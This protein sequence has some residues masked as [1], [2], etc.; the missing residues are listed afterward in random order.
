VCIVSHNSLVYYSLRRLSLARAIPVNRGI[1]L[2]RIGLERG[3]PLLNVLE[4][5]T[6]HFGVTRV[7]GVG[8][9]V[10]Q[11]S[12]VE[13]QALEFALQCKLFRSELR[14]LFVALA[15]FGEIL[16]R[17]DVFA[18]PS[19]CHKLRES[20]WQLGLCRLLRLQRLDKS[21]RY[22]CGEACATHGEHLTSLRESCDPTAL[23]RDT[24]ATMF[25][26]QFQIPR[27]SGRDEVGIDAFCHAA[28]DDLHLLVEQ[29]VVEDNLQR[30]A[31]FDAGVGN[32]NQF[33]FLMLK[34]TREELP[35]IGI[36]VD[37]LDAAAQQVARFVDFRA[38]STASVGMPGDTGDV[39]DAKRQIAQSG[40]HVART[41]NDGANAQC[42][43][44]QAFTVELILGQG[45]RKERVVD[46]FGEVFDFLRDVVAF[47]GTGLGLTVCGGG[48]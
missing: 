4:G 26:D 30:C 7:P 29:F 16:L 42:A 27:F 15:L 22:G 13:L 6:D 44:G 36:G 2:F 40:I 35:G 34:L 43:G 25:E 9:I 17:L 10:Q 45:W 8:K 37:L 5:L 47:F 39:D 18:L 31:G 21:L 41:N 32:L 23:D 3:Q 48:V 24:K 14:A 20:G 11:A 12:A 19:T 38:G 46:L 28:D 1:P 33:H